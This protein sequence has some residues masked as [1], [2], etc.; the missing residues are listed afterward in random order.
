MNHQDKLFIGG[1]FVA[2]DAGTTIDILNPHDGRVLASV[3]EA[4]EAD[5]DRAVEAAQAAFGEW[6]CLPAMDRGRLLLKLADAI[7]ANTEEIARLE[8]LDAKINPQK[9]R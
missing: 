1:E 6:S 8:S 9:Q 3:A 7:E 2:A 5:V 4:R